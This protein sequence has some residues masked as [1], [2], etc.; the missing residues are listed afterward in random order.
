MA[1]RVVISNSAGRTV[2][3]PVKGN[4]D[5]ITAFAQRMAPLYAKRWGTPVEVSYEAS[6][7]APVEDAPEIN[8]NLGNLPQVEG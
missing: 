6:E 3:L 7:D 1:G 8:F 5:H 2:K 4:N